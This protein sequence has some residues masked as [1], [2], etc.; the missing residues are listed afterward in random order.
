MCLKQEGK[1]VKIDGEEGI[2]L[3]NGREKRV[4]LT[5]RFREGETVSIF[6]NIAFK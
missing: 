3:V 5:A 1:L 2:V 6:Q 4:T